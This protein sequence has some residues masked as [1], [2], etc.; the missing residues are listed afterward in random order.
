MRKTGQL[1]T[2]AALLFLSVVTLTCFVSASGQDSLDGG[3][4]FGTDYDFG[5]QTVT[6]CHW[7]KE[8]LLPRFDEGGL[9]EG[10]L[11]EA[12]KL[13]NC[14]IEFDGVLYNDIGE[15]YLARLMSGASR[16]DIWRVQ[17]IIA[18]WP[19]ASM[20]A[21]Y[22]IETI[23][24]EDYWDSL[25]PYARYSAESM[26]Y[27]GKRL[28]FSAQTYYPEGS[29]PV[30]SGLYLVFF[31]NDMLEE[32]GVESPYELYKADQWTWDKFAEIA[33]KMTIDID[34]DGETDIWGS[35]M[36]VDWLAVPFVQANGAEFTTIDENGRV[37][38]SLG[39]EETE[40][41]VQQLY[42]WTCV[43]RIFSPSWNMEQAFTSGQTAMMLY[44]LWLYETFA[45]QVDFRIGIVPI[46][47]G[48]H[49]DRY[50]TPAHGLDGVVLPAN[51]E[52][53]EALMALYEF[54]YRDTDEVVLEQADRSLNMFMSREAL[55]VAMT[56]T[57]E[58]RGE[59][60]T[61]YC[62][63]LCY[64]DLYTNV[65]GVLNDVILGTSTF[66]QAIGTR[67]PV[68]QGIL[69]SLFNRSQ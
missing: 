67:T 62:G 45:K 27:N 46:P 3:G 66:S 51:A 25:T 10:R 32:A 43:D 52:N 57:E 19:L 36:I 54:L 31:N 26:R 60:V 23:V 28:S 61:L 58:W 59:V 39:G 63:E 41:A 33:K 50:V 35:T 6:I 48:P 2:L 68:I 15:W 53:P 7:N 4:Y 24:G 38:F 65:R 21:L 13:F 18:Y 56:L 40:V 30:N 16:N 37:V 9:A 55:E 69:D 20:N 64:P 5:G 47:K 44:P 12:E 17:N 1:K 42:E 22:D 8:N 11:A 34:A 14:K 49:A 29:M